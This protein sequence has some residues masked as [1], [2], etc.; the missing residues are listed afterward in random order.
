LNQKAEIDLGSNIPGSSGNPG[1]ETVFLESLKVDAKVL[2]CII[3]KEIGAI[4]A[5]PITGFMWS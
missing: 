3:M 5:K 1:E 2:C 4:I